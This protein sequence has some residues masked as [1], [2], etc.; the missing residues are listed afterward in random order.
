MLAMSTLAPELTKSASGII[1]LARNTG[2]AVGL[3]VLSSQLTTRT[4]AHMS[5]LASAISLTSA[6]A[7]GMVASLADRMA[8]MGVADPPGA[9]RK[10]FEFMLSRNAQVLAFG[11]GFALLAAG[12][13]AAAGIALLARPGPLQ[14]WGKPLAQE[15]H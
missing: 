14:V 5:D 1:N 10:A 15:A 11:D 6:R 12:C 8:I 3:A 13:V 7:Q 2:G 4:A 9:A